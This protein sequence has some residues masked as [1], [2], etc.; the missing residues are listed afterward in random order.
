MVAGA[1][2]GGASGFTGKE[3]ASI[4]DSKGA[5]GSSKILPGVVESVSGYFV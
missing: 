4:M 2:V 3:L 1:A 5:A